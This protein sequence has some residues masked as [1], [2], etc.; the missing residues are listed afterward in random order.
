M[1]NFNK[2]VNFFKIHCSE[3][4]SMVEDNKTIQVFSHN[5]IMLN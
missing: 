1:L 2:F 5:F 3:I 4:H